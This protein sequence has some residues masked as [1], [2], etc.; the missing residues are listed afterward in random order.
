M[1]NYVLGIELLVIGMGTVF[2]SLYLLSVFLHFSGKLL[3]STKK[4]KIKNGDKNLNLKAT[5]VKEGANKLEERSSKIS[6]KKVAA[7]SAAIY[8]SLDKEKKY[9]IISIRKN[10]KNWKNRR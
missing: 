3:G 5:N 7:I 2:L 8:E 10:N 4:I 9:K 6:P 1:N